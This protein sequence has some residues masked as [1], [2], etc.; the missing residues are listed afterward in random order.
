M[1]LK[2]GLN[3]LIFEGNTAVYSFTV[4]KPWYRNGVA[5]FFYLIIGIVLHKSSI[6]LIRVITKRKTS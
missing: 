1:C 5:L 2:L 6:K 4:L 3:L